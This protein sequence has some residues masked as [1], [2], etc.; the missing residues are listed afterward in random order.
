MKKI[1]FLIFVSLAITA[2]FGKKASKPVQGDFDYA[3]ISAEGGK[4]KL[5]YLSERP[6]NLDPAA[7]LFV[8][9]KPGTITVGSLRSSNE[10]NYFIMANPM[11]KKQLSKL[12]GSE[13]G[14]DAAFSTPFEQIE[15][16]LAKLK[17][18]NPGE[19]FSLPSAQQWDFAFLSGKISE[20]DQPICWEWVVMK[21]GGAYTWRGRMWH[22]MELYEEEE[23]EK[24]TDAVQGDLGFRFV[25]RENQAK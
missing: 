8:K 21:E 2:C 6:K 11:T 9:V 7:L 22:I 20:N 1:L 18:D 17:K 3:L 16:A 23:Q 19:Q 13:D 5:E 25:L 12:I 10:E 24:Q 15:K 14:D 4:A